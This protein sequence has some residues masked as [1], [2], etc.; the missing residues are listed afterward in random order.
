MALTLGHN[1]QNFGRLDSA[2]TFG[3]DR[4]S[5]PLVRSFFA[6]S[7]LFFSTSGLLTR[8]VQIVSGAHTQ[9][10]PQYAVQR[11]DIEHRELT[12]LPHDDMETS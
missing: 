7:D 3:S 1:R 9:S 4:L 8:I 10:C 11:G 5:Y 12:Q 2:A 6:L